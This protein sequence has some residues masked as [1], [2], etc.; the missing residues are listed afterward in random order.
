MAV[1]RGSGQIEIRESSEESDAAVASSSEEDREH[2]EEVGYFEQHYRSAGLPSNQIKLKSFISS[3]TGFVYEIEFEQGT[4]LWL[5][6]VIRI[7]AN[8]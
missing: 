2:E 1:V 8:Y 3:S 6:F 4:A 5:P 7:G